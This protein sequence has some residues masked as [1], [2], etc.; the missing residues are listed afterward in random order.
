MK[1]GAK[2]NINNRPKEIV[3]YHSKGKCEGSYVIKSM[4]SFCIA[5][6]CP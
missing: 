2:I 5:N 4:A 6:A 1:A 3:K